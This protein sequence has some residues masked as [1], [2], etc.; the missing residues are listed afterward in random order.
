MIK[1]GKGGSDPFV[2]TSRVLWDAGDGS[3]VS[4]DPVG[5]DVV[6]FD[7]SGK[8]VVGVDSGVTFKEE[9]IKGNLSNWQAVKPNP[10]NESFR[11]S[12]RFST[13]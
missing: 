8:S 10:S 3:T 12:R 6:L 1:D 7:E 4:E 2:G 13:I 5:G 9:G 11:K